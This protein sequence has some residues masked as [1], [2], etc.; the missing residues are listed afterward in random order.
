LFVSW[1][2][3]FGF[4]ISLLPLPQLLPDD[5]VERKIRDK[6]AQLFGLFLDLPPVPRSRRLPLGVPSAWHDLYPHYG[7]HGIPK[8]LHRLSRQN[9]AVVAGRRGDCCCTRIA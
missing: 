4:V 2:S 7:I 9:D 1:D 5:F 3:V 8:I 6:L